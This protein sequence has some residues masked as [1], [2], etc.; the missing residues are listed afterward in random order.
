M[1]KT[2]GICISNDPATATATQLNIKIIKLWSHK[3]ERILKILEPKQDT[4]KLRKQACKASTQSSK[5]ARKQSTTARRRGSKAKNRRIAELCPL[6]P[7]TL[8]WTTTV[9]YVVMSVSNPVLLQP[10]PAYFCY[11]ADCSVE[12]ATELAQPGRV[13]V[14]LLRRRL[15]PSTA[16]Q[17]N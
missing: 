7:A 5:Q 16:K 6:L 8:S 17:S 14:F 13:V 9:L 10:G 12:F 2:I 11:A 15:Q 1:G 3:P 4:T